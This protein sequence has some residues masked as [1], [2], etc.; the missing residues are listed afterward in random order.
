MFVNQV[1]NCA[2]PKLW[3]S[4]CMPL[5][6]FWP[7]V[8]GAG[9]ECLRRPRAGATLRA[10]LRCLSSPYSPTMFLKHFNV[11]LVLAVAIIGVFAQN[12]QC[13]NGCIQY[14][15][16]DCY[17]GYGYPYW[18]HFLCHWSRF[19][20]NSTVNYQCICNNFVY[21]EDTLVCLAQ[22]C[23]YLDTKVFLDALAQVCTGFK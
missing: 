7:G 17:G 18:S 14:G 5:T 10:F 15:A 1:V 4:I 2:R 9:E 22:Y 13:I 23:K 6:Y 16:A 8:E 19:H 3:G 21:Q 20:I 12:E 11:L